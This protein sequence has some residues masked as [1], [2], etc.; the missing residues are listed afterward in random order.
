MKKKRGEK[1]AL[2]FLA[3]WSTPVYC[4][5]NALTQYKTAMVCF[6]GNFLFIQDGGWLVRLPEDGTASSNCGQLGRP[7][8]F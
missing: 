1:G 6:W 3:S 8:L 5:S 4:V 2:L 7:G